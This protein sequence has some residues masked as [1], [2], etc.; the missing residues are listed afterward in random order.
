M[1]QIQ[2]LLKRVSRGPRLSMD[3]GQK[4]A[5]TNAYLAGQRRR[6]VA[7]TPIDFKPRSGS[8]YFLQN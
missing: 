5:L 3:K 8:D 2:I 4:V 6:F 1:K 7:E